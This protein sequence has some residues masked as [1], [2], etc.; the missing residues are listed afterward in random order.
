MKDAQIHQFPSV[1]GGWCGTE[2]S[3]KPPP[4]T[5]GRK[6]EEERERRGESSKE[7]G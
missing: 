6:K 7:V 2:S 1:R 3:D 5:T 4:A